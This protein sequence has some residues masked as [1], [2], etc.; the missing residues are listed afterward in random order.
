MGRRDSPKRWSRRGGC[1]ESAY[2]N[3][4][5]EHGR[6]IGSGTVRRSGGGFRLRADSPG[7]LGR[8]ERCAPGR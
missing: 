5:A 7:F 8:R 1:P 2:C 6:V 4:G 3:L